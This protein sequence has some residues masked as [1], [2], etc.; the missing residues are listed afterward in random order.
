[1]LIVRD[2]AGQ[3]CD[4]VLD[5]LSKDMIHSHLKSIVDQEA[6]LC[7]DG[8]SYYKSFA[9]QKQIAHHRFIIL[10]KQHVIGKELPFPTR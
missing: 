2:R 3:I 9:Q 6:M 8:A 10:D 1:M 4:F 7:T 5:K